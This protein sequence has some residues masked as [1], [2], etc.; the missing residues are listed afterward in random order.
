MG[1]PRRWARVFPGPPPGPSL[2]L[3]LLLLRPPGLGLASLRLLDHPAPVCSQ[4]VRSDPS[5]GVEVGGWGRVGVGLAQDAV[6]PAGGRGQG[7]E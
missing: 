7:L 4:E 3:F 5:R 2:L 6:G 1:A